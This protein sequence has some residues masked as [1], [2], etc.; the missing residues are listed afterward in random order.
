MY[1]R[2]VL[3]EPPLLDKMIP[4]QFDA[5]APAAQR[6]CTHVSDHCISHPPLP[7]ILPLIPSDGP[8]PYGGRRTA[9]HVESPAISAPPP[10]HHRA[11]CMYGGLRVRIRA[12][13][14]QKKKIYTSY[15]L[16]EFPPSLPITTPTPA[17]RASMAAS[18][19]AVA[20][21]MRSS[22]AATTAAATA[23]TAEEVVA[24]AASSP[25]RARGTVETMAALCEKSAF[26]TKLRSTEERVN[27]SKDPT[28][29]EQRCPTTGRWRRLG[30]EGS[31]EGLRNNPN[32][33]RY[34]THG[35]YLRGFHVHTHCNFYWWVC[36]LP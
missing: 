11:G 1:E 14:Y 8:S 20:A 33:Q 15:F 9:H 30:E 28:R 36:A 19:A 10:C 21:T 29:H 17:T 26:L 2:S 16:L 25:T 31:G 18:I 13:P 27:Q 12:L 32:V 5:M 35:K 4:P 23:I 34:H 24:A 7:P 3:M 22:T 6:D